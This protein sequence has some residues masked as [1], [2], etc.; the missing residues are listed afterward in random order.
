VRQHSGVM[1]VQSAAGEGSCFEVW[2]PCQATAQPAA[3]VDA[4]TLPLGCGQTVLI[5][6]SGDARL[7]RDE[8]MLAALGYEP[9]GFSSAEAALA[10]CRA[11]PGRF[12][13]LVVGYLGSTAASLELAAALHA[14]APRVPI[15]LASKS[16]EEIG[17]DT[18]V[19]AGVTDV[20]HWPIVASQIAAALHHGPAERL[21]PKPRSSAL[22]KAYSWEH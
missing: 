21:D 8:E 15:V 11:A 1:N 17:A 6:A 9:V 10:A 22:H 18:L 19:A 12:D 20:V 5:V 14:A 4:S 3:E 16:T 2:L 13:T 7:L